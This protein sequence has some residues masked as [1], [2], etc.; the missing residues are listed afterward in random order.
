MRGTAASNVPASSR[1]QQLL[2]LLFL[3]CRADS[4]CPHN[5]AITPRSAASCSDLSQRSFSNLLGSNDVCGASNFEDPHGVACAGPT[6]KCCHTTTFLAAH[7]ICIHAGARLCSLEELQDNE[8]A[9]TGCGFDAKH[10]WTSTRGVCAEGAF[11]AAAGN[12]AHQNQVDNIPAECTS[13]GH[14]LAV[15]CCGDAVAADTEED[16]CDS[17]ASLLTCG[18]L[19]TI[20]G[21]EWADG[22]T[23]TFCHEQFAT[24]NSCSSYCGGIAARQCR[25][26][27]M[28]AMGQEEQAG[29]CEC[30]ADMEITLAPCTRTSIVALSDGMSAITHVHEQWDLHC[31]WAFVGCDAGFGISLDFSQLETDAQALVHLYSVDYRPGALRPR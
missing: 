21:A 7:E 13:L 20:S 4:P 11:M 8:A 31:S 16:T 30:C 23:A 2:L 24:Q 10:V 25:T 5:V 9:G 27:E 12:V 17:M 14:H 18:E 1:Q 6:E 26:L 28:D 3:A 22:A 19:R 29:V 15:R